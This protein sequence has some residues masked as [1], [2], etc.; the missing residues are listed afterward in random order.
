L[1]TLASSLTDQQIEEL[2][3][4][5]GG[6]HYGHVMPLRNQAKLTI[7]NALK[8][9]A[10]PAP[11]VQFNEADLMVRYPN[12]NKLQLFG[13][14]NPD[15]LRGPGFSGLSFDEYSQHPPNLFGEVLSKSL[16]DH[17]GYAIFAGTIKGKDQLF[18]MHERAK[19]NPEWFTTWQDADASVAT[20]DDATIVL[21]RQ[22]MTDDRG[23][24]E[25]GLMTQAEYDQ[26]WFLSAEA[27]IKG[28]WFGAEMAAA[29]QAGRVTTGPYD[30][31]LPV[32]TD[33]DLGVDDSTSIWFS[34][35][36]RSGDIRLID[37]Y[38]AS[39]EG[40]SHYVNMLH[41]K[42]SARKY[43][44]GQHWAPHDIQVRELGT[45]KT[46]RETAASLGIKFEIVPRHELADGMNAVRLTLPKCWFDEAKCARGLE[47]LR[48]YRKQ[49]NPRLQE[50]TGTPVH[51]WS[52]H[53]ADAF[54]GLAVRHKTPETP[55]PH[56]YEYQYSYRMP[57]PLDWMGV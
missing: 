23:L 43:V 47:A 1:R 55:R 11:G 32:D 41:E 10:G 20:E 24:I 15:A 25:T 8:Y 9:Y 45:G 22:A 27:A 42:R 29:Q 37:Y 26:E 51:D 36:S 14:D 53:A 12:G 28:A 13:A 5:P 46:R 39:G 49:L 16:A 40:L 7:W 35:S 3:H 33:W 17:L 52:S 34:Q 18:R 31:A 21:L 50:F 6:R 30:P 2:L 44:Y 56:D 38:E 48:Q 19:S 54:R 57:H 4:P